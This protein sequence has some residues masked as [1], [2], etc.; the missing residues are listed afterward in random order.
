[1]Q[2]DEE[3]FGIHYTDNELLSEDVDAVY[4]KEVKTVGETDR[5]KRLVRCADRAPQIVE[6]ESNG[7]SQLWILSL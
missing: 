5:E 7:G 1:M 6:V 2:R 3:E 4:M